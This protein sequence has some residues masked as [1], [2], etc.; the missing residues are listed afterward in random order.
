MGVHERRICIT[1]AMET[2]EL[3]GRE[4]QPA[5][6][7]IDSQMVKTTESGRIAGYDDGKTISG[8]KHDAVVDAVALLFGLVV[9]VPDIQDREGAPNVPHS[10][11]HARPWLISI[12]ADGGFAE[13]KLGLAFDR[14]GA[15]TIQIVERPG[16]AKALKSCP[17][18]GSSNGLSHGSGDVADYQII[19]RHPSLQ[20]RR[21]SISPTSA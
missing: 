2:H 13:P 19:G 17:A 9:R 15:W 1:L 11:R 5:A 3:E 10:M 14:I 21:A 20:V 18:D 8:R 12:F 6:G 16:T 7:V 4:A